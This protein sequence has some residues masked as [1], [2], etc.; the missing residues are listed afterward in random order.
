[1]AQS[2]DAFVPLEA[3]G[4]IPED[5][6]TNSKRKYEE[7]KQS[8]EDSSQSNKSRK[9]KERFYLESNF[10]I[11]Q[12]LTSGRVLFNDPVSNY[13]SAILDTIL[14]DNLPLRK[15][16]RVYA[17]KST[18]VN[19]FTTNDGIILVNVGLIAQLENEAQLAY[20]L[21]HEISHYTESHVINTFV[22]REELKSEGKLQRTNF[23]SKLL[24]QSQYSKDLEKEA[25]ELGIKRFLNTN[26]STASVA[27]VFEVMRYA[28]LPFDDV[29]FDKAFFNQGFYK[30]DDS[31]YLNRVRPVE[32][33]G[34]GRGSR[35]HPSPGE[36]QMLLKTYLATSKPKQ[37]KDY[38]IG[39]SSFENVRNICRFELSELHLKSNSPVKTIYNSYLLLKSFEDNA[40]L[41][42]SIAKALY[43]LSK[44]KTGG[45]YGFVHPGFSHIEGE[46]QQLYHMLYR[47]KPHELCVLATGY[48]WRLREEIPNEADLNEMS[49][50]L[51]NDLMR[52]YY[53]LGM[54]S[55]VNPPEGWDKPD[56]TNITSKYDRLRQK[57]KL[58]P[59]LS[60]VKYALVDVFQQA[61]FTAQFDSLEQLYWGSK[62]EFPEGEDP[63]KNNLRHWKNHGFA[64]GAE[65]VVVV[66]PIY[67]KLDLRKK[68]QQ[69]FL[70][71]E[72][73]KSKL[74]KQINR[75][76]KLLNLEVEIIDQADVDSTQ[77][78][79]FNDVTFLNE[80]V[81][82]R[83]T[84]IEVSMVNMPS[85]KIDYLINKYQTEHFAW[86]GVINY[87]ESKPLMYW[88]LLYVLIPPAI[89][90]AAY[91]L[92]SP[93]YDTYYYCIVFN[94]KTG[95]P[96][97][98]NYS[99]FRKRDARDMI[100]SNVYDSF[101][102]MK[103]KPKSKK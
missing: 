69:K 51:L 42:T 48:L 49:R 79:V 15:Q 88:Y 54:F 28:H 11:D 27:N 6:T 103:R 13:L 47:L 36:R 53:V 44:F 73:A 85:D 76:S 16:I 25:D 5:I 4:I 7:A 60:M 34:T 99:N 41:K 86:T 63:D 10:L 75:S 40:Y 50:D 23:D 101:W 3:S 97:L 89:P 39:K 64:L 20:I 8:L 37:G 84:D 1:M 17:V 9:A 77:I 12:V 18:V 56:T 98:V 59:K 14:V 45:N 93:N 70:H 82:S 91:S 92:I 43:K 32:P 95:E 22:Q 65:K 57:A 31:Y 33:L 67:A 2:P 21:C 30:I 38:L 94:I 61:T 90:F 68:Q 83:F 96:V 71:S 66:S 102:Q 81:D 80:W 78:E 19:S 52:Q 87:R 74:L 62:K 55:K 29:S 24:E 46:S 35:T 72:S 26:Y 100:N 58:N